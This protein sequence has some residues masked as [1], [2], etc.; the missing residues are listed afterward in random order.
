MKFVPTP[1]AGVVVVEPEP[2]ADER[3]VFARAWCVDEFAA[4]GL[5]A[6]FVQSSISSNRRKHTVR[7]LH[8]ALAP[9]REA[10]LVRAITGAIFDVVVDLREGSPTFGTSFSIELDAASGRAVYI[11][12]QCAHGFQTLA[13]ETEVLYCMTDVYRPELARTWHWRSSDFAIRWPSHDDITI[14]DADAN[15]AAFEGPH[16]MGRDG[17]GDRPR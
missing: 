3:G 13:P 10:K 17:S 2:H 8:Y 12:A 11:P 9:S 6:R 4:A 16:P 7:G 15:A 5:D 1:L 14:S